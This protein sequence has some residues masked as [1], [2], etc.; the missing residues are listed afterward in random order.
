MPNTEQGVVW[1]GEQ[2][3]VVQLPMVRRVCDFWDITKKDATET[4]D[5]SLSA[6]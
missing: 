2:P 1:W 5:L 4:A 6:A 3:L